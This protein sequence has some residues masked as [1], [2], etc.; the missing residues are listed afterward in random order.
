MP[1][2]D[3]TVTTQVNDGVARVEFFHPK[4]NSL[5]GSLLA[6]IAVAID[7]LAARDDVGV[8]VLQSGGEGPFCAGASF[9]ELRAIRTP[10]QGKEFFSGFANVILAIRRLPKLVLARVQGRAVGGGVGLAAAADYAL[11]SGKAAIKL[12]ELV[13]G[14]G[15]FVIGPCVE[16]RLGLAAFSQLA[17]DTEW[18]SAQWAR[19]HGLYS[20]VFADRPQLDSATDRLARRLADAGPKAMARLKAVLWEGTDDWERLLM[21]RAAISGELVLSKYAQRT[22]RALTRRQGLA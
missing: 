6:E 15:P 10:R 18:R 19:R 2:V 12:S 11:A 20:Q 9:D 1:S 13:L 3:G 5:P 16:R 21:E 8:V 14:I 22:L 4:K 7:D 17:I